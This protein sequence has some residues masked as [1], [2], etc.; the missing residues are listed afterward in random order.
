[1]IARCDACGR[2]YL[3]ID[4]RR[5]AEP[6]PRC[7]ACLVDDIETDTA[8]DIRAAADALR[9]LVSVPFSWFHGRERGKRGKLQGV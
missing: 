8:D 5:V 7:V 4:A 2:S 1:M 9:V 6:R 3:E